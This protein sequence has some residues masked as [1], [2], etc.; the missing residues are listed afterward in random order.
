VD[1]YSR[2]DGCAGA[3][4]NAAD[5]QGV[6]GGQRRDM[7]PV[8]PGLPVAIRGYGMSE[9]LLDPEE[10]AAIQAAI[11]DSR[12]K[13]ARPS[14]AAAAAH[15]DPEDV[16][17]LALIADDRA[18]ETAR[19]SGMRI[20]ERWCA[21][22]RGRLRHFFS[23]DLEITAINCE[24]IDGAAVRDELAA[25]WLATVAPLDRPGPALLAIGG[26]VIEAVAARLLGARTVSDVIDRPPSVTA[27]SVFAP[28]GSGLA[29]SFAR[30][31]A[32]EDGCDVT[33]SSN[34]DRIELARRQ[35][36][37]ADVLMA[38][39][40]TF[41][42]AT[43]GRAR[44][45]ARPVTLVLPPAP[46]K[47]IPAAPGAI[48]E[49]L[50]AVSIEIRV[51]LGKAKLTMRQ[52]SKLRVGTVIPLTTFIDDALPVHCAGVIK[53]YGR[54]VVSRGALAVEITLPEQVAKGKRAA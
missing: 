21:F 17:P 49:A 13:P 30:A 23:G 34:R 53:A 16:V 40:V 37:E 41:A 8:L 46:V 14:S 26:P 50:G 52:V 24:V 39:T 3:V 15:F 7:P 22:A 42:G 25:M 45:F 19:P 43:S 4:V 38:V 5:G 11:R 12:A 29:D 51:D 10:L 33:A 36:C 6:T 18:A 44:L 54:A 1:L 9:H 31:W 32:E 48:E 2:R 27:L 20:A 28:V 47:A 35:L